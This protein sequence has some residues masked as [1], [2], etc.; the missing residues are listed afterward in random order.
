MSRARNTSP[1]GKVRDCAQRAKSRF[2]SAVSSSKFRLSVIPHLTV[3]TC[4]RYHWDNLLVRT[5]KP[6]WRR[7]SLHLRMPR[8]ESRQEKAGKKAIEMVRRVEVE[9]ATQPEPMSTQRRSHVLGTRSN[10][11]YVVG[12]SHLDPT[13]RNAMHA[14]R[15]GEPL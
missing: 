11:V 12:E 2:S 10:A 7:T 9:F 13:S 4:F 3:E 14:H 15:S 8:R 1:A 5:E 6:C